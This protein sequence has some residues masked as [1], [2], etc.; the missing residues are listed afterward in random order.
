MKFVDL[1]RYVRDGIAGVAETQRIARA[2]FPSLVRESNLVLWRQGE[3]AEYPC[4]I[5]LGV[6]PS[7]SIPDLEL[8]DIV[9]RCIAEQP[10]PKFRVEVFDIIDCPDMAS[11]E[12]YIVG[13]TPVFHTPVVGIWKNGE[14]V[15]K[16]S[17][18]A[19][20]KLLLAEFQK[21]TKS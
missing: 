2:Q 3:I 11:L 6:A 8:L 13:I 9:D 20:R 14:L 16:G 1:L 4:R 10:E 5:V 21:C 18:H 15:S 7:Y 17:G 12:K 19:G